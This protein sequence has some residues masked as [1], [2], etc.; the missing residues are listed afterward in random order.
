MRQPPGSG[1]LFARTKPACE[2]VAGLES[3]I[4][5]GNP[6]TKL[7]WK[8]GAAWRNRISTLEIRLSPR[9][10]QVQ[11]LMLVRLTRSRRLTAGWIAALVY[12]LCVLAPGAALAFG[13]GPAPCFIDE[14]IPVAVIVK[15]DASGPMTH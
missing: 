9:W 8:P 13:R 10:R 2:A 5:C 3:W 6:I 12:L 14:F 4:T 11:A 7:G 15:S 1:T